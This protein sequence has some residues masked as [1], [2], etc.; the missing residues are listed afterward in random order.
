[1]SAAKREPRE[2]TLAEIGYDF[3]IAGASY[4]WGARWCPAVFRRD[5]GGY[6]IR[7]VKTQTVSGDD[8]RTT[9]DYFELDADGLITVAPRGFAREYKPGRVVDIAAQ[10]ER[11]AT[12][13][14]DAAR[15]GLP[16]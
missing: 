10:A 12:P 2:I 6:A 5:H 3:D 4:W 9:F 1:V 11:Y 16:R 15:I 14:P 7:Y 13:D 8:V